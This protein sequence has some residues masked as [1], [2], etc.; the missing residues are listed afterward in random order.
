MLGSINFIKSV[1]DYFEVPKDDDICLV[2]NGSSCGLNDCLWA[3]N[4]WLPMP[5]AA[6]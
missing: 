3:P 1:I 6:A 4:F 2:Y 5:G